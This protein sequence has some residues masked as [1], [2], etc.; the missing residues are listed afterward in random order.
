MK[1][2]QGGSTEARERAP[3]VLDGIVTGAPRARGLGRGRLRTTWVLVARHDEP[4]EDFFLDSPFG[5]EAGGDEDPVAW[6]CRG[7]RADGTVR[8]G[9]VD[10]DVDRFAS[11]VLAMV[12]GRSRR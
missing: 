8:L 6:I 10:F 9:A 4:V 3:R 7:V 5:D 12:G 2:L 1:D 11:D